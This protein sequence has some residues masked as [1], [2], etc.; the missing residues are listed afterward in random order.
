M[1]SQSE[2]R[3]MARPS[4]RA[5]R[6]EDVERRR[7][8]LPPASTAGVFASGPMRSIAALARAI[9]SERVSAGGRQ[10]G[11]DVA[12]HAALVREMRRATA[13]AKAPAGGPDGAFR[14]SGA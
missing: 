1:P 14:K 2:P 10:A 7:H 3:A 8:G 11:Y 6:S 4:I 12:R 5:W 13:K 9:R